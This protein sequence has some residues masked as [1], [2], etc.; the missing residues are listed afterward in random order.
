[1]EARDA[2]IAT[3]CFRIAKLVSLPTPLTA[4]ERLALLGR[5]QRELLNNVSA[6]FLWLQVLLGTG[7]DIHRFWLCPSTSHHLILDCILAAAARFQVEC[8]GMRDWM[9][10]GL[11]TVRGWK[12]AVGKASLCCARHL[13]AAG[14]SA[15]AA[16]CMRV[17]WMHAYGQILSS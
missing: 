9:P 3:P 10:P 15:F 1:M 16:C 2:E 17:Q 8:I 13:S 12:A 4:P 5:S 7:G 11:V 14:C 6:I